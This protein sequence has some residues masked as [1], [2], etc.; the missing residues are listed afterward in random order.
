MR[1]S[2]VSVVLRELGCLDRL[3]DQSLKAVPPLTFEEGR[4][5]ANREIP[6]AVPARAFA[7][8]EPRDPKEQVVPQE[9]L[10]HAHERPGEGV[11]EGYPLR[12][13]QVFILLEPPLDF[14]PVVPESFELVVN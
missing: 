5:P 12:S 9:P 11:Q 6:L 2:P 3:I 4:N 7:V 10:H 8:G 14:T 13:K 1:D